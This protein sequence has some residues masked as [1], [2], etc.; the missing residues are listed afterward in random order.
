VQKYNHFPNYQ[1]FF[2][3]IFQSKCVELNFQSFE[4]KKNFSSSQK[5]YPKSYCSA[6]KNQKIGQ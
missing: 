3:N 2:E 5:K 6:V 1:I 4:F